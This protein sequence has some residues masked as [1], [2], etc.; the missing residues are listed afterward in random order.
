M[1]T[2]LTIRNFKRFEEVEIEL[3]NPVVFIGPNNSGKTSAMQALAL[4]D[5]GLRRWNEKRKGR[6]APEKR[7]GVT[8]NRRDLVAIP[9]PSANLLWREL[10]TRNV[11][12]VEGRQRTDNIRVEV[13]VEGTSVSRPADNGSEPAPPRADSAG[14]PWACGLE[15]DYANQ[16]SF[17]CRPLRLGDG[18]T[19]ERMAVPEAAGGVEVAYLPPMSGLAATETRL[20]PGAINV[21]VGEGRTAEVLRNLCFQIHEDDVGSWE[22]LAERIGDLFGAELEPPFY[23]DERGEITMRYRENGV[24]LDLSSSGRGLQQTLLILAYMYAKPRSVLLLD[25]PDAHLEFL[26]Q[27]QIYS[28]I[29]E[30]A[31]ESGSQIVAA[32]HSEVLLNEAAGTDTVVAFVGKPH[33]IDDRSS[34]VAKA[35]KRIGFEQYV[36]AEQVGWVLYLEGSTDFEILKSFARRLGHQEGLRVLERPFLHYVGNK[37]SNAEDHYWG[38]REAVPGLL[39]VAVLDEMPTVAGD[40]LRRLGWKN[41]E[42]EN[43][44]CTWT[45]LEAYVRAT[46]EQ[47]APGPLFADVEVQRRLKALKG[48]VDE[49]ESALATFDRPPI[50]SSEVKASDDVLTPLF[51]G[52]FR[53]LR[54]PNLM[55]KTN[56]HRLAEFVPEQEIDSEIVEKLDAIVKV[57]EAAEAARNGS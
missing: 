38:L 43:Y 41:R 33:R 48:A 53:R 35:L 40:G 26:R 16:E 42:I 21:R 3:A 37:F 57:A 32:S 23:V 25:E 5:I 56:F 34:Q 9:V 36:L 14:E 4:W 52:Y 54:Q 46:A 24:W 55:A 6:T 51:R 11:H 29:R 45:T 44:F 47:E 19:P 13:I 30:V 22:R 28:L 31:S 2:K 18:G 7:P 50:W 39:G 27:R 12:T 15:F 10:H 17:Y 1:F 49:V 8:V 20:D